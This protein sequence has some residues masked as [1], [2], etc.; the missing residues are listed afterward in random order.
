MNNGVKSKK[1]MY[2]EVALG[3]E[4]SEVD[5]RDGRMIEQ[6]MQTIAEHDTQQ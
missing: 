3:V 4:V 5:R 6:T 1:D 2:D